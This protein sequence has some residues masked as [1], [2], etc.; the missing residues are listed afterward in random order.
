MDV[1][2]KDTV[3]ES[4][5]DGLSNKVTDLSNRAWNLLDA[6]ADGDEECFSDLLEI[7]RRGRVV[8]GSVGVEIEGVVER[9]VAEVDEEIVESVA[10]VWQ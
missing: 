10:E 5:S 8:A 7:L 3:W 9:F 1:R 2:S 6:L 4:R